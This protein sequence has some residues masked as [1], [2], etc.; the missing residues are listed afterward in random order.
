MWLSRG[1]CPA[2]V[3]PPSLKTSTSLVSIYCVLVTQSCLFAIP[4]TIQLASLLCP[5]DS[6]AKNTGVG[7]HA[8]LQGIFPTQR[9]N[10]GLPHCRWILYFT[11]FYSYF[12]LSHQ[13]SPRILR[14]VT[15]PFT[16]LPHPGIKPGPPALQADSLPTELSGKPFIR[17]WTAAIS[18]TSKSKVQDFIHQHLM[19]WM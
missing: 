19:C 13:G 18:V 1:L 17:Y 15:Y 14:W 7:C 8:L 6:P 5:R 11:L 12:I 3:P 16:S 4:W 10:L 9:S 2:A